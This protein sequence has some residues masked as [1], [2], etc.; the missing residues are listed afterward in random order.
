MKGRTKEAIVIDFKYL[1]DS[2]QNG[3]SF[4]LLVKKSNMSFHVQVI[5]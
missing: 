3:T 2:G 4:I 5:W 1:T